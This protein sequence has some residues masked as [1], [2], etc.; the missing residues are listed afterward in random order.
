MPLH[1]KKNGG[2]DALSDQAGTDEEEDAKKDFFESMVYWKQ[3]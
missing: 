3:E 1:G 2:G